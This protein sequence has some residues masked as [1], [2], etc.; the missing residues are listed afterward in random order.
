M[1]PDDI[2]KLL[3][4]PHADPAVRQMLAVHRQRREP[5][6]E[7]DGDG[8]ILKVQDFLTGRRRG[9]EF[10]F[11]DQGSFEQD[12]QRYWGKGPMLLT[13][14][15]FYGDHPNV[16]PYT[17][18]RLPFGLALGD[19]RTA[20]RKKLAA[21]DRS[22]RSWKRDTWDLPEGILVVAYTE[23]DE[24]IA[25]IQVSLPVPPSKTLDVVQHQPTI[26]E[27]ISLLGRRMDD[28]EF[29]RLTRSLQIGRSLKSYGNVLNARLT[30][31]YGLELHF[32]GA[33]NL[34]AAALTSIYLYR[35]REDAA[36]GWTGDLP[37]HLQ[38]NDSPELVIR[39][40]GQ[41]TLLN[42]DEDFACY[43][44]WHFDEYSLQL[45]F[46]TMFNWIVKV[47]ILAPGTWP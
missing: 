41:P 42:D 33:T 17:A 19:S 23:N 3:G 4:R 11:E 13:Q 14:I 44:L 6:V 32:G 39:R 47:R 8:E 27:L 24:R 34:D 25:F 46:S 43:V 38:W 45:T 40:L 37:Q 5:K 28:A 31:E 21:Y 9:I 12:D 15:Y 36:R 35:D 7:R 20:V 30:V 10:G 2:L 18:D 22:R 1:A 26:D 29:R 16:H